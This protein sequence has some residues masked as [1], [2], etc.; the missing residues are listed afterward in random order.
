MTDLVHLLKRV[1]PAVVA[2]VHRQEGETGAFDQTVIG[3]GFNIDESGIVVTCR[4]VLEP[5]LKDRLAPPTLWAVFVSV[6]VQEEA[7]RFLLSPISYAFSY[8][9]QDLAVVRLRNPDH[10]LPFLSLGSTENVTEGSRVV[11]CGYPLGWALQ[12]LGKS[13]SSTFQVGIVSSV[14]PHPAFPR[15]KLQFYRLD[16]PLNPGNSGG[17]VFLE[18]DGTVVGTVY[19]RPQD[20]HSI[21][22]PGDAGKLHV[23]IPSGLTHALP[24]DHVE[25][26]LI[27][28]LKRLT[29]AEID[30]ISAGQMPSWLREGMQKLQG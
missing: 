3:T 11:V 28:L 27:A 26:E 7:V 6:D 4:H 14:I 17:P 20:I 1:K 24:I 19:E 10:R 5:F 8:S 22:L 13:V 30:S 9:H 29:I 16:I 2:I 21:T 15:R 23:P 25:P 18:S 12:E